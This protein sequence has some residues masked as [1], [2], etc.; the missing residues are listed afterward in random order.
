MPAG[1]AGIR[2]EEGL[3]GFLAEQGSKRIAKQDLW[4]LVG[5]SLRLTY[6]TWVAWR[7]VTLTPH[8]RI[9]AQ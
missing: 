4:R 2:L 9:E 8:F 5:G 7:S 1:N 6:G 3:R